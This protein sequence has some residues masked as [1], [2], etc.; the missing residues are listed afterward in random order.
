MSHFLCAVAVPPSTPGERP[1]VFHSFCKVQPWTLIRVY[2]DTTL[3]MHV[4]SVVCRWCASIRHATS[5]YAITYY[6]TVAAAFMLFG[7]SSLQVGSGYSLTE[8]RSLGLKLKPHWKPF[9]TKRP[10]DCIILAPGFKASPLTVCPFV[11]M[12]KMSHS[13]YKHNTFHFWF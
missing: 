5:L 10:P 7:P 13:M 12:D 8:L 6:P 9:D 11:A 4:A 3:H 1:S 2:T